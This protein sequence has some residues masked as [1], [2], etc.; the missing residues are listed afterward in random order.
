M[1]WFFSRSTTVSHRHGSPY[2]THGTQVSAKHRPSAM[3]LNNSR[4]PFTKWNRA[5]VTRSGAPVLVG[6]WDSPMRSHGALL[7]L[8]SF[9]NKEIV[10]LG[11][12]SKYQLGNEIT[13]E[14]ESC[15]ARV[16]TAIAQCLLQSDGLIISTQAPWRLNKA[17]RHPGDQTDIWDW[18]T[19]L[20]GATS[21]HI[22]PWFLWF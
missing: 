3:P 8:N 6:R 11:I 2:G 19:I 21:L 18:E 1:L 13:W 12:E 7:S 15:S 22:C 4:L 14:I 16:N 20:R 10:K 17:Q 9:E 5:F